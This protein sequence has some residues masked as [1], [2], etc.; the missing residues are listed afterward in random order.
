MQQSTSRAPRTAQQRR[1]QRNR[2]QHRLLTQLLRLL[3]PQLPE[4]RG[5]NVGPFIQVFA[6][7]LHQTHGHR[8]TSRSPPSS[9]ARTSTSPSPPTVAAPQTPQPVLVIPVRRSA[10][11]VQHAEQLA[12]AYTPTR[13]VPGAGPEAR[14]APSERP[15]AGTMIYDMAATDTE[16]PRRTLRRHDAFHEALVHGVPDHLRVN[17]ALVAA[18]VGCSRDSA[19]RALADCENDL[20]DA[21]NMLYENPDMRPSG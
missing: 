21:I 10:R 2:Q 4:H 13:R 5:H 12:T 19:L 7:A 1:D 9:T 20:A 11:P 16:R 14:V 8:S 17:A 18:Q 6:H 3:P 15:C